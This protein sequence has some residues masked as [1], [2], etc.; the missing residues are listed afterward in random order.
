MLPYTSKDE[1]D[2]FF[3][4]ILTALIWRAGDHLFLR[5]SRQIRPTND[6][7][8]DKFSNLVNS[9]RALMKSYKFAPKH[10]S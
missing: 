3:S 5:M 9:A 10:F 1:E 7:K 4:L 8:L 6:T 2:A